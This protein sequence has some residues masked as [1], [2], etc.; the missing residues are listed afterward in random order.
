MPFPWRD[1]LGGLGLPILVV[2]IVLSPAIVGA[3]IGE[4]IRFFKNIFGRGDEE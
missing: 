4:I 2:L 3:L 1:V